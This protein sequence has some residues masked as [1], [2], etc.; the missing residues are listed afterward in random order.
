M[1]NRGRLLEIEGTLK[2][3]RMTLAGADRLPDGSPRQV[4]GIWTP[5][6]NGVR[7]TAFTSTDAGRTWQPWFDLVFRPHVDGA[8]L[9]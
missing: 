7:E 1:T 3:G 9:R 8:T 6:G 2:D 4:R 5:V